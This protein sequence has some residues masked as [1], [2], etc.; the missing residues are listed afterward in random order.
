MAH[1]PRNVRVAGSALPLAV[2]TAGCGTSSGEDS[3]SDPGDGGSTE[4]LIGNIT[5]TTDPN[6]CRTR[7]R[8]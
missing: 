5:S 1:R 6:R 7:A 8:G 3:S 4:I 2:A